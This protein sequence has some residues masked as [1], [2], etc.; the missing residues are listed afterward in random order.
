MERESIQL[1]CK[2]REGEFS[3][4]WSGMLNKTSKVAV[5]VSKIGKTS[6][7]EFLQEAAVMT[8]LRHKQLVKV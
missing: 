2:L 8:R 3:E 5:K 6:R 7:M 4:E 1:T